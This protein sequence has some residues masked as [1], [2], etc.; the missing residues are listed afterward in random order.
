MRVFKQK[1]FA[2]W[3]RKKG[4][5]D[6]TLW[7]AAQEI[8]NGIF[9][10]DLGK[11]LYKKRVAR[12]NE[13]SSGGF[14][15]IVVFKKPKSNRIFFIDALEKSDVDNF[16]AKELA[17]FIKLAP[18]LIALTDKQIEDSKSEGDFLE[19]EEPQP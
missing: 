12:E 19:I 6:S 9:D 11:G 13:G 2:K 18:L 15:V 1:S 3:A 7:N 8:V 4:V 10:A 5:G 14:R 17:A 16:K